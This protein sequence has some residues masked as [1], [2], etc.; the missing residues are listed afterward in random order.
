M[1][2]TNYDFIVC[3]NKTLRRR[4]LNFLM[5]GHSGELYR[6]GRSQNN[7]MNVS[8]KVGISK[9]KNVHHRVKENCAFMSTQVTYETH[10]ISV[11]CH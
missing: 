5:Y 11:L 6:V 8:L 3:Y 9:N 10:H 4:Q 2:F 1:L 7:N